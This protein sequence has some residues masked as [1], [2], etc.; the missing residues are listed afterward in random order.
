MTD[1]TI[2]PRQRLRRLGSFLGACVL[3]LALSFAIAWPLWIFAT[4]ARRA[5]GAAAA[6]SLV[7]LTVLAVVRRMRMRPRDGRGRA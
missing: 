6:L 5:I 4:G 2:S 7:S 3:V 1:D